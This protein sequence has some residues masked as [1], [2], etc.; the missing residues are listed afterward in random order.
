[1][2]SGQIGLKYDKGDASSCLKFEILHQFIHYMH[3]QRWR[4]LEKCKMCLLTNHVHTEITYVTD[5]IITHKT[6]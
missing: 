6:E 3:E 2:F 1:M 5:C 4:E